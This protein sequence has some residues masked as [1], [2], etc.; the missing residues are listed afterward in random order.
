MIKP[1]LILAGV[2]AV[3]AVAGAAQ[4]GAIDKACQKSER[5]GNRALCGC[6]QQVADMTLSGN[7]Q[8]RA[9]GF[10]KEPDKAQQVRQSDHSSD[11]SF[12]LRYKAFAE[13]AEALC[14]R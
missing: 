1:F 6:I 11:E 8:R 7:D 5:P 13:T 3:C 14:A 12:W 9:A 10:F 2:V 4:A